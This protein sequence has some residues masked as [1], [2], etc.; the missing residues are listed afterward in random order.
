MSLIN[1][2]SDDES[3]WMTENKRLH[4]KYGY[5]ILKSKD[6]AHDSL[7]DLEYRLWFGRLLWSVEGFSFAC[8]V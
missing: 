8:A 5:T 7:E 3:T 2:E 4:A 1:G 6:W